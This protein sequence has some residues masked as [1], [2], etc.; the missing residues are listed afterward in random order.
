MKLEILL[1]SISLLVLNSCGSGPTEVT[2]PVKKDSVTVKTNPAD[3][4]RRDVIYPQE[5]YSPRKSAF[6]GYFV[7]I[8]NRNYYC[9]Y[10]GRFEA[11]DTLGNNRTFL[12]DLKAE[13]LIDKMFMYPVDS[14]SW[15]VYWQETDHTGVGCRAALFRKGVA[16]PIW[17]R[18]YAD[19]E[20]G[21]IAVYANYAYITSLGMVAKIDMKSGEYAWHHDSLFEPLKSRF[22]KF[23]RPLLYNTTVCFFDYPIRGRKNRRD[24][25]CVNDVS[26]KIIR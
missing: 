14:I 13:Y 7:R 8:D 18:T 15:F 21:Q 23:D 19:P 9:G 5:M 12:F 22:K 11:A 16:K 4:F 6:D 17:K 2:V 1:I 24:T 3:S 26:G 10:K 25:I 20:P